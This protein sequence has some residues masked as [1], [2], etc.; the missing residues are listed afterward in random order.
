LLAG[1]IAFVL[2]GLLLPRGFAE[3]G[4]G[5]GLNIE[6]QKAR[7]E[8]Q[9]DVLKEEALLEP[10]KANDIKDK[11]EQLRRDALGKEPTKTL[12]ALDHPKD[13]VSRTAR[14]A[15]ESIARKNE[16]LGQAETLADRLRK[17]QP[18]DKEMSAKEM[19]E[20]M[21]QLAALTRKAAAE[22]ELLQ[23]DLDK[24]DR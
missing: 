6:K 16:T 3:M 9:V 12:E 4:S 19:A 21:K 22:N 5:P 7:L 10:R 13:E 2:L 17:K 11:L 14:K 8:K 20:A 1:G 23:Q 18:G 15:A 24:L